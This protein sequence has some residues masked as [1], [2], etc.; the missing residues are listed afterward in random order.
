[1]L[2]RATFVAKQKSPKIGLE[3]TVL[4][5]PSDLAEYLSTSF[6]HTPK[7][8]NGSA[9]Q[10]AHRGL[11][12]QTEWIFVLS[13]GYFEF[14]SYRRETTGECTSLVPPP[15]DQKI[16]LPTAEALSEAERAGRENRHFAKGAAMCAVLTTERSCRKRCDRQVLSAKFLLDR[17]RPVFFV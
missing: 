15:E 1:M 4:R 17:A 7:I 2:R 13:G 11:R 16:S 9:T 8:G 10:S 12:R 6:F 3:P 5:T 14:R